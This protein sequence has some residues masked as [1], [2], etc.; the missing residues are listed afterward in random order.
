MAQGAKPGMCKPTSFGAALFIKDVAKVTSVG[1][2][3]CSAVGPLLEGVDDGFT[4]QG[5]SNPRLG[6]APQLLPFTLKPA[7]AP[8]DGL[9]GR[10]IATFGSMSTSRQ[11]STVL[12]EAAVARALARH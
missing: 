8:A 4:T 3:A 2:V 9:S 7:P 5:D 11:A 12:E 6:E 10:F 1:D